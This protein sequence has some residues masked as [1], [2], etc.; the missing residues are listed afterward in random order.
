MCHN[1]SLLGRK[2][3]VCQHQWST[4]STV[5][6]KH[7]NFL[8]SSP[9]TQNLVKKSAWVPQHRHLPKITNY[10]SV[11]INR[12]T[13]DSPSSRSSALCSCDWFDDTTRDKPISSFSRPTTTSS[14]RGETDNAI[15]LIESNDWLNTCLDHLPVGSKLI[16]TFCCEKVLEFSQLNHDIKL[17]GRIRLADHGHW[18]HSRHQ[19]CQMT[20]DYWMHLQ[21]KNFINAMFLSCAQKSTDT[22][23]TQK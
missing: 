14:L 23:P 13:C 3:W 17:E 20:I 6:I 2:N 1:D 18:L 11:H 8:V 21:D 19:D 9:E 12:S 16:I 22:S 4:Y 15:S 5:P 7:V 10:L